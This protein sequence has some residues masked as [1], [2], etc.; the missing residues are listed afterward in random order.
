MFIQF[1]SFHVL[2]FY[3]YNEIVNFCFKGAS[4]NMTLNNRKTYPYSNIDMLPGD[5]LYSTIGRS[6][7]YVGHAVIVGID[8]T[9]K[10]SLPGKPSGHMLTIEQFWH[11]HLPGDKI[12]LLRSKTGAIKAAKWATKHLHL[13]KDYTIL[14]H[15]IASMEKNYCSKWIVQAYYYGSNGKLTNYLNRFISPQQLKRTKRLEKIAIFLKADE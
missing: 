2:T 10:E 6:T 15:D 9:I 12:T 11:R 4:Y 7:Y 14:N 3:R 1:A 8:Y 13:V 5:I